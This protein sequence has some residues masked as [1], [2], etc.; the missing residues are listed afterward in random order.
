MQKIKLKSNDFL[1]QQNERQ[2]IQ[3]DLNN[4][5]LE[6]DKNRKM[7]SDIQKDYLNMQE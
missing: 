3:N 6:V 2:R 4:Q 1:A 7:L 5:K